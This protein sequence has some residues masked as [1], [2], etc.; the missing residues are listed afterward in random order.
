MP[1]PRLTDEEREERRIARNATRRQKRA[2]E[3]LRILI[4]RVPHEDRTLFQGALNAR[5]SLTGALK[6]KAEHIVIMWQE[7]MPKAGW[8]DDAQ[9]V[10]AGTRP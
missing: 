9:E 3:K 10:I 7:R 5:A 4:D 2:D 8:R 1:R 6:A